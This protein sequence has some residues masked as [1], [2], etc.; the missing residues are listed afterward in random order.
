M[1]VIRLDGSEKSQGH[2][3]HFWAAI[4]A[5]D[6]KGA[7]KAATLGGIVKALRAI[8][9]QVEV[10]IRHPETGEMVPGTYW[11]LNDDGGEMWLEKDEH[12]ELLDRLENAVEWKADAADVAQETFAVLRDA[13]TE[14]PRK[15]ALVEDEK[16]RKKLK[17]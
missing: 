1:R 17:A 16:P 8:G 11:K 10:K 12:A 9:H 4:R 13:P 15:P 14:D 3:S 5:R 2:Y 6:F 7:E